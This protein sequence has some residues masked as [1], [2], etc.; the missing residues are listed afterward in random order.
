MNFNY[1]I[2]KVLLASMSFC[3]KTDP[4]E[5]HHGMSN[6]R[7]GPRSGHIALSRRAR[8]G[9]GQSTTTSEV[10]PKHAFPVPVQTRAESKRVSCG[11]AAKRQTREKEIESVKRVKSAL[12]GSLCPL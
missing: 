3:S 11:S 2:I 8:K 6:S 9:A 12:T 4:G 7:Q 10:E 5:S 1:A